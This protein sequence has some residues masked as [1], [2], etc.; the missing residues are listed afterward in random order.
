[1]PLVRN[2]IAL[3]ERSHSELMGKMRDLTGLANPNS[4]A[5]L[6][7]WLAGEGLALEHLGKKEVAALTMRQSL[8]KSSVSK[9]RAMENCVCADSRVRGLFQFYGANRTGRWSG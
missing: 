7:G 1:M 6:K 2:A 5:Q 9:Y 4:A 3:D 8:S